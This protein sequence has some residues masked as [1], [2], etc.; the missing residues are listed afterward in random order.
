[1]IKQ[2]LKEY[3]DIDDEEFQI[4]EGEVGEVSQS[5]GIHYMNNHSTLVPIGANYQA[6]IPSII[7]EQIYKRKSAESLANLKHLKVNDPQ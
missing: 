4:I 1:M 3:E 5:S 7:P 6:H 2:A